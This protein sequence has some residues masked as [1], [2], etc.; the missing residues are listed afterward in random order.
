[1]MTMTLPGRS[2]GSSLE[3]FGLRG[4]ASPTPV[5]R[6]AG[7]GSLVRPLPSHRLSHDHEETTIVSPVVGLML[8][9]GHSGLLTRVALRRTTKRGGGTGIHLN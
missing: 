3:S 5:A 8:V 4:S 6:R 2:R 9:I 7:L 1:M